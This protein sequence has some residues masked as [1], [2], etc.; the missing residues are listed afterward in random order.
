MSEQFI[1]AP[2]EMVPKL[3]NIEK[4]KAVAAEFVATRIESLIKEKDLSLLASAREV[5]EE[6]KGHAYREE[7]A[8][9]KLLEYLQKQNE[10]YLLQDEVKRREGEIKNDFPGISHLTRRTAANDELYSV[11]A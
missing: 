3:S 8:V 10:L 4:E 5:Y 7:Q 9:A 1:S 2:I 6:V 11:A